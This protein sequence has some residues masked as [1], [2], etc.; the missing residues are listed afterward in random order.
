[1][2]GSWPEADE[3]LSIDGLGAEVAATLVTVPL[4]ASVLSFAVAHPIGS[5]TFYTSFHERTP[6][7]AGWVVAVTMAAVLAWAVVVVRRQRSRVGPEDQS[8]AL[9]ATERWPDHRSPR[10]SVPPSAK[11]RDMAR[12]SIVVVLV[13][14]IAGVT[15]AACGSPSS[16]AILQC[17]AHP[18][19]LAAPTAQASSDQ[20]MLYSD[21]DKIIKY[22]VAHPDTYGGFQT[23]QHGDIIPE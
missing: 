10:S 9:P 6:P 4:I 2:V 1:M 14:L 11:L 8:G 13:M 21:A 3:P 23:S 15:V 19:T 7:V 12:P 18:L 16:S 20:S 17:P 5:G 22:G